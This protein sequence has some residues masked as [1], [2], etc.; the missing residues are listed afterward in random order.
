MKWIRNPKKQQAEEIN[1]YIDDPNQ[2]AGLDD[3]TRQ[4]LD[5]VRQ[6]AEEIRP[7]PQ[8]VNRLSTRLQHGSANTPVTAY[9]N[10]ARFMGQWTPRLAGAGLDWP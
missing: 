7:S 8:F 6:S 9:Q 1:R 5:S 2:A 3:E 10:L 4:V